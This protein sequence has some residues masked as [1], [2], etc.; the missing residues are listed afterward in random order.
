M[1]VKTYSI[2]ND[3]T[4]YTG[5]PSRVYLGDLQDQVN[6]SELIS[7]DCD[8]INA[9]GDNVY[10]HFISGL[11]GSETTALNAI[12]SNFDNPQPPE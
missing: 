1:S 3:F 6:A 5:D 7:K 12:I 4:S 11:S 2:A 9:S 10:I 8:V